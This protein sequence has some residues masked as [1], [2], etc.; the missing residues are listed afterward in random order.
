MTS[1][2]RVLKTIRGEKADRTPLY[3]WVSANLSEEIEERYGEIT[4]DILLEKGVVLPAVEGDWTNAKN[5]LVHHKQRD[6]FCYIQTPGFFEYFNGIFGIENQLMYLLIYREEIAELYAKQAD[7][8]IGFVDCCIDMGVDCIHIS[9]DWG[10]QRDM[11]F[12]PALWSELIKPNLQRVVNHVHSRGM[13][14]SLHSDGCIAR[15]TDELAEI[16]LDMLHPWQESAGMSYDTYLEKY[17]DHFALLGGICVQTA[18]GIL[19][20]EKLEAEIRRVFG[21]LKDKRWICCTS[22]FVQK[23][24]SMEDLKFAFDLIYRL[25]RE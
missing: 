7:W 11:L 17:A 24:C 13:L 15:I 20:R 9:D 12:S 16:G 1:K 21:L 10:S 2:E 8:L 23:H 22:H 3:G 4:P 25:A 5:A 18:I 19:P 6:R 14:V